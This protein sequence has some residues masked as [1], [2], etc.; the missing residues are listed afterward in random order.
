M[1]DSFTPA[2]PWDTEGAAPQP[3]YAFS[4]PGIDTYEAP[5]ADDYLLTKEQ[6]WKVVK[7]M[8]NL[9]NYS[10]G[11]WCNG[12]DDVS[13][14]ECQLQ[15]IQDPPNLS[16]EKTCCM[17]YV[18]NQMDPDLPT[19]SPSDS[20]SP[21]ASP[22][23]RSSTTGAP[24]TAAPTTA[25]PEGASIAPTPPPATAAPTVPPSLSPSAMP[26]DGPTN[27]DS[28]VTT[29]F[30]DQSGYTIAFHFG[31]VAIDGSTA[32][33]TS[34]ISRQGVVTT[35]V[36][37]S[38]TFNVD[39]A[40]A[41]S[42]SVVAT[43]DTHY[44]IV[45]EYAEECNDRIEDGAYGTEAFEALF[46]TAF[47]FLLIESLFV[48]GSA[49]AHIMKIDESD[50][51]VWKTSWYY[52]AT[53]SVFFISKLFCFIVLIFLLNQNRHEGCPRYGPSSNVDGY[54]TSIGALVFVQYISLFAEGMSRLAWPGT[55]DADGGNASY[56]ALMVSML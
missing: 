52:V 34:E 56:K 50:D 51:S 36:S 10:A 49:V 16:D 3:S 43:L 30:Y 1:I 4:V 6:C 17:I 45:R 41:S 38:T 46:F 29:K 27:E 14:L 39:L 23:S 5:I 48:V 21:T 31:T 53:K 9:G 22:S 33:C 12:I 40:I 47:V 7:K 26:T 19:N 8:F 18:T 24:T 15:R 44:E 35:L 32:T 25:A 54:A 20:A 13:S 2:I 28:I 42:V 55:H 37:N 11:A